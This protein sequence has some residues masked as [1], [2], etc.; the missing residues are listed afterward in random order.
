MLWKI[1][2]SS[3]KKKVTHEIIEPQTDKAAVKNFL[4]GRALI[5]QGKEDEAIKALSKAIE[6]YERHAFAYERRGMVNYKFK[7]YKDAIYDFSKSIDLNPSNPL[8]YYGRAKVRMV[9]DEKELAAKDFTMAAKTSIPLQ[10]IHIKSRRQKAEL[11]VE[12]G[13]GESA[14]FD[15][16]FLSNRTYEESDSFFPYHKSVCYAYGKL[17]LELEKP[18]EAISIFEKVMSMPD[19]SVK[20]DKAD[21]LMNYGVALQKSGKKGFKKNWKNAAELGSK[22]AKNLLIEFA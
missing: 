14:E 19:G 22:E 7:N 17:L 8:A 13:Q 9:L 12:L 21:L 18:T 3:S 5:G 2:D 20:I 1:D 4:K 6:K 10:S 16:K 11:L 15:L